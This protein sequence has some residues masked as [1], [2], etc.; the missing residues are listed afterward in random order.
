MLTKREEE[1]AKVVMRCATTLLRE[2]CLSLGVPCNSCILMARLTARMLEFINIPSRPVATIATVTNRT[3]ATWIRNPET[4]GWPSR[5]ELMALKA[6][7]GKMVVIGGGAQQVTKRFGLD[8][9]EVVATGEGIWPAHAVLEVAGRWYC[10]PS[11][12]QA[13]ALAARLGGNGPAIKATPGW[14][15]VDNFSDWAI[16]QKRSETMVVY[17]AIDPPTS[18]EE[19]TDWNLEPVELRIMDGFLQQTINEYLEASL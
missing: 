11:I 14:A 17:N 5:E 16:W 12:D 18:W 10:D 15:E 19:N 9:N 6:A 1:R 3:I 8:P 7:G 13:N 4:K 2:K